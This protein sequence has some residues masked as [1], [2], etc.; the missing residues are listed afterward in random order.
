[1]TRAA[2]PS[3]TIEEIS[4]KKPDNPARLLRILEANLSRV[5]PT[6]EPELASRLREMLARLRA[7]TEEHNGH[8]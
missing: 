4:R 5:S 7:T 2:T 6:R 3:A 1:M 8:A